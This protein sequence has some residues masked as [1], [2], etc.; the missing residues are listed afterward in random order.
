[1]YV[2]FVMDKMARGMMFLRTPV[3]YSNFH[4]TGY[5]VSLLS[6]ESGAVAHLQLRYQ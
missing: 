3:S 2:E 4:A 6:S 1:M 5:I